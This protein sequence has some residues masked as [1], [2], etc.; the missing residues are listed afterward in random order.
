[1][2]VYSQAEVLPPSSLII[3]SRNRP[4]LLRETI[5]SILRGVD[6][7]SELIVVDQSNETDSG[8]A[9]LQS[10][11]PCLVRY[12]WERSTGLCRAR[13]VGIGAATNEILVFTDDDMLVATDSYGT[14]VRALIQAGPG[15]VVTGRV[16][17]A[18]DRRGGYVPALVTGTE[19]REYRG[20][21]WTDVLAA[22]HMAMY[23]ETIAE[24]GWF[25]E[26]LGAGSQFPAADDNDYGY[27][28][29]EAGY[30]IR[31]V[32]AAVIYHR[33]W[34]GARDYLPMRWNYGRG[35]GGFYAKYADARDPY[36]LY[37]MGLDVGRRLF[38]FP[39]RFLHRP[40]LAVGDMVYSLGVLSGACTWLLTRP[41]MRG[42]SMSPD[43]VC[44]GAY[45]RSG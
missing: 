17:P 33:A 31:Y 27:R 3:C 12:F 11:R 18:E 25:D 1:M 34:R 10:D 2:G 5:E 26:R 36:L 16:L 28:L 39:W 35:K 14:L 29:L 44:R 40:D 24:I 6:V 42:D 43:R 19:A 22:G 37:R 9:S 7:P 32:P 20:R 13:N 8:L 38:R 41:K 21:I 45:R 23:R 4:R 15:G 30:R